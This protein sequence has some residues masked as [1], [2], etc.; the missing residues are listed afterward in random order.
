ML[1]FAAFCASFAQAKHDWCVHPEQ[2]KCKFVSNMKGWVVGMTVVTN[3]ST[4]PPKGKF[5]PGIDLFTNLISR[6]AKIVCYNA[7]ED[8]NVG[9]D[10]DLPFSIKKKAWYYKDEDEPVVKYAPKNRKFSYNF[11]QKEYSELDY[12]LVFKDIIYPLDI[13]AVSSKLSYKSTLAE[14]FSEGFD[15]LDD[16]MNMGLYSN[17]T[18]GWFIADPVTLATANRI[19]Y[20]GGEILT[21]KCKIKVS[22]NAKSWLLNY[23]ITDPAGKWVVPG[24]NRDLGVKWLKIDGQ[25]I[26]DGMQG[27]NFLFTND[28][29]VLYNCRGSKIEFK[30]GLDIMCPYGSTNI[31][32]SLE[33]SLWGS[34]GFCNFRGYGRVTF[35]GPETA[36]KLKDCAMLLNVVERFNADD[37]PEVI[38]DNEDYISAPFELLIDGKSAHINKKGKGWEYKHGSLYLNNFQGTNIFC[39]GYLKVYLE[40]G[41]KNRVIGGID[42]GYGNMRFFGNTNTT[43]TVGSFDH[44]FGDILFS[45]LTVN[46]KSSQ[47]VTDLSVFSGNLYARDSVINIEPKEGSSAML[48]VANGNIAIS[49]STLNVT[50]NDELALMTDGS[51]Q[52]VNSYLDSDGALEIAENSKILNSKV[53]VGSVGKYSMCVSGNLLSNETEMDL[54]SRLIVKGTAEIYNGT[55]TVGPDRFGD[56]LSVQGVTQATN[57]EI[58]VT[59]CASFLTNVVMR[60]C[61][62]FITSDRTNVFSCEHSLDMSKSKL[63]AESLAKTVVCKNFQADDSVAEFKTADSGPGLV[64]ENIVL[65]GGET[66]LRSCLE[67][68][69]FLMYSGS[70]FSEGH[71]ALAATE[72]VEFKGGRAKITGETEAVSCP[73]AV[74]LSDGTKEDLNGYQYVEIEDGLVKRKE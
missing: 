65:K 62:F 46:V 60:Q 15:I 43:L 49:N 74:K 51:L 21:N 40:P 72:S 32:D 34:Y 12:C 29:L 56:A 10:A 13:S 48:Y 1:L 20:K 27:E 67:C 50:A 25:E 26:T 42:S 73:K 58:H 44:S 71:V 66:D 5:Y 17:Q 54:G 68:A 11:P 9:T 7:W 18:N 35:R 8:P 36:L 6:G 19:V 52:V 57:A 41:S 55:A 70:L 2:A 59:G 4:L 38:V 24:S 64:A 63:T 33:H 61:D 16:E 39:D 47:G 37:M 31:F 23:K 30:G 3:F 69:N 14:D 22:F 45:N 28:V 53:S